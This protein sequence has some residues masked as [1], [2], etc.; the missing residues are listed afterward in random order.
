MA[1][2]AATRDASALH[3][4]KLGA[5][6]VFVLSAARVAAQSAP[7]VPVLDLNVGLERAAT[8][9][10]AL[11]AGAGQAG[12]VQL[13]K[14]HVS[15]LMTPFPMQPADR[16]SA[17]EML[18]LRESLSRSERFDSFGCAA[19]SARIRTWFELVDP[20]ELAAAP[21]SVPLWLTRGVVAFRLVNG[22]DSALASS[23]A[24]PPAALVI[25]LTPAGRDV[26]SRILAAQALID[27]AQLSSLAFDEVIQL[28]LAAHRPVIATHTA[29]A[30]LAA[31][32]WNLTNQQ[33]VDIARTGGLVALTF[34]R[35]QIAPGRTARIDHIVSQIMHL[36]RTVGSEHVAIGSSFETGEDVPLDLESAAQFPRLAARLLAAGL[37]RSEVDGI[38]H[39]NAERVLCSAS[40]APR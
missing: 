17:T 39:A 32:R 34:D 4:A 30:A 31:H 14:G 11:A 6:V 26:V 13:R 19:K 20:G 36:V 37:S 40:L 15:G 5:L 21:S 33:L 12:Y 3:L 8:M 35:R 25:G 7:T 27:V 1:R 22:H 2:V 23:A 10:G 28:A 24:T 29:A 16:D 18:R 38:F 9:P